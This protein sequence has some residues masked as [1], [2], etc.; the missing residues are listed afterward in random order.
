MAKS[1]LFKRIER[2]NDEARNWNLRSIA[3]RKGVRFKD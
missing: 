1:D 3:S 2:A